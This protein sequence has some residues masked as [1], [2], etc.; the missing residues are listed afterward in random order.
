MK[1]YLLL[2]VAIQKSSYLNNISMGL[3]QARRLPIRVNFNELK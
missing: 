3:S 1:E 2:S